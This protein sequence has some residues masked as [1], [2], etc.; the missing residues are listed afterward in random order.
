M[1]LSMMDIKY[2]YCYAEW[3]RIFYVVLS[4]FVMH[5]I[6]LSVVYAECCGAKNWAML[7]TFLIHHNKL[8]CLSQAKIHL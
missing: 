6:M 8:E 4:V 7:K 1:T 5:V 2:K 3:C